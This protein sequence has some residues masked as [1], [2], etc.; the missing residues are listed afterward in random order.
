MVDDTI[1]GQYW[2]I[3]IPYDSIATIENQYS[4]YFA[5]NLGLSESE[6]NASIEPRGTLD[7]HIW[8]SDAYGSTACLE[9]NLMGCVFV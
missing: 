8:G 6:D 2:F 5:K 7:T 9:L 1:H 4:K 3:T